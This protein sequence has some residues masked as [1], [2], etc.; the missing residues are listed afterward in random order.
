MALRAARECVRVLNRL[1]GCSLRVDVSPDDSGLRISDGQDHVHI[2]QSGSKS[3]A[4]RVERAAV[5][6]L[7]HDLDVA[8]A[9]EPEGSGVRR[10]RNGLSDSTSAIT[11]KPLRPDLVARGVQAKRRRVS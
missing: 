7:D 4:T 5:Q 8:G 2:C 9:E 10:Q 11:R 1:E 6:D 3:P